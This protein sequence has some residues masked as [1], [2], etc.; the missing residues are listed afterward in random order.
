MRKSIWPMPC[1]ASSE[2]GPTPAG[3]IGGMFDRIAPTYDRLNHLLSLGRD[4]AWRRLAADRIEKERP[5]RIADL[6]TGTADLLIALLKNHPNITEAVGLDISAP[7][8]EI[9]RRKVRRQGFEDRVRL[10]C[11]DVTQTPFPEESLDGVTM[12]FGIRNVTDMRRTLGEIYRILKPGG[13]AVIL[14]FSL[15]GHRIVKAGYLAYL[16]F[17]VP[18]VGGFLS[19]D[20]G[21]YQ[22]LN[23]SI[24]TFDSPDKFCKL[25]E[26]SG[27]SQVE[28]IP[29]TY[30]IASIYEGT[31]GMTCA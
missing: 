23:Q 10:I 28:V 22:Y 26:Q 3:A 29:L 9:G 6:A 25:M 24:E 4:F 18:L 17:I 31:K 20:R 2:S 14:E 27:F 7:M 5:I 12:A 13:K 15:P 8:L 30:G 11:A 1:K 16:R 19:G 21:A